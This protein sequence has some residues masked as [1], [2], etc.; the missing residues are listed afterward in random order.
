MFAADSRKGLMLQSPSASIDRFETNVLPP[1][2]A[3]ISWQPPALYIVESLALR[4]LGDAGQ[5]K[6]LGWLGD[7]GWQT[8]LR[9]LASRRANT[10]RYSIIGLKRLIEAVMPYGASLCHRSPPTGSDF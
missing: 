9:D 8:A 2:A 6:A 3:T 5:H 7:A 1:H 10:F 4:W